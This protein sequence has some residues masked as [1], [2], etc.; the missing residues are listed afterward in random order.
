VEK[1]NTCT[2]AHN[3]ANRHKYSKAC[4][5]DF[6]GKAVHPRISS[7]INMQV[8][9]AVLLPVCSYEWGMF[10]SLLRSRSTGR[11]QTISTL[12]LLPFLKQMI[13]EL[14]LAARSGLEDLDNCVILSILGPVWFATGGR[15][16]CK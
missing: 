14:K 11:A 4:A 10:I 1:D 16:K 15:K 6:A 9:I 12:C 5:C 3:H 8:W 13:N 7:P 2:Q